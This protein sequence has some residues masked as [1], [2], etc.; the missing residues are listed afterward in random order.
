MDNSVRTMVYQDLL[1]LIDTKVSAD[2][3]SI[4]VMREYGVTE[5]WTKLFTMDCHRVLGLE[6]TET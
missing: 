3:C 2:G 1:A 6:K 4:W 5:S